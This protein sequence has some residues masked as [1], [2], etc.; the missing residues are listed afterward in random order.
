VTPH[1]VI[2]GAAK[3]I[4]FYKKAFLR[5]V[6]GLMIGALGLGVIAGAATGEDIMKGKVDTGHVIHLEAIV[7]APPSEVYRLWTTADGLKEFFA[8]DAKVEARVGG[9]YEIIFYPKEDPEGE[10]HGT[11]GARILR[12]VPNRELAFE[13][14]TFVTRDIPGSVHPPIV[15]AA[16]KNES[17]IPV[18]VEM[19]FEA[20]AGHP[21]KTHL[22]LDSF[23]YRTGAEW[24][25]A[26]RFFWKNWALA[27]GELGAHCAA[28]APHP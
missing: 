27:L 2:R 11:K 19:K 14:T 21:N 8:P 7:D 24:D 28:R 20:V 4:E 3:A 26:F 17:P 23:G 18:W 13:W 12:L 15:S 16:Q 5:V 6:L 22:R 25:E 9:R 1:W 10:S